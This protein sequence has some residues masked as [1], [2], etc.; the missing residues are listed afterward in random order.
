MPWSA[1][2][3][4]PARA[5]APDPSGTYRRPDRTPF[6]PDALPAADAAAPAASATERAVPQAD[7]EP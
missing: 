7:G 1:L 3:R 6:P 4:Q 5:H 2:D